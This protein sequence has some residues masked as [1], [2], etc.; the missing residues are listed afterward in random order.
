MSYC[1]QIIL[2]F[3]IFLCSG[4]AIQEQVVG[5]FYLEQENYAKGAAHF[6]EKVAEN[7]LDAP[8]HYYLGR[9][10]LNQKDH[11]KALSS[12]QR[13][14]ELDNTKASYFSWLGVAYA[15]NK[16][17]KNERNAYEKAL[18]I[19]KDNL[20]ALIYLAHNYFERQEY[21]KAYEYYQRLLSHT[22]HHQSA[23]YNQTVALQKLGRI[24]EEKLALMLYLKAHPSGAL[25]RKCVDR[26]NSLGDFSYRNFLI[27]LRTITLN[28]ITFEPFSDTL[29]DKAEKSLDILAAILK[30][31]QT[32]EIHIVAYQTNH[33][34]LA[35]A[36][37]LSVKKYLLKEAPSIAS[38]RLKL[39]W[40]DTPKH[41]RSITP[42]ATLYESIEFI[43]IVK[44]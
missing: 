22:P 6:Q 8:S 5:E 30:Q 11:K 31:N 40:F 42:K 28:H 9:F 1:K 39:S 13:A 34:A 35:K 41:I 23:L 21:Q 32:L 10:Y 18:Q 17:S 24:S 16:D 15:L 43:T 25:A 36:R 20:Q 27:G 33:L 19:D 44:K 7:P 37:A 26:L 29:S 38:K 4:C 12:L 3:F 14:I 2:L